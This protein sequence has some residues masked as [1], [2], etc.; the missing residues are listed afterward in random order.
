[1]RE[2]KKGS[3]C[4]REKEGSVCV[5]E[6][7]RKRVV[8]SYCV[9]VTGREIE[10]SVCLREGERKKVVY[11]REKECERYNIKIWFLIY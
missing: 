4:E 9:C 3:V 5:R 10:G 1:M 7:E 11:V 6:T 8:C 2:R